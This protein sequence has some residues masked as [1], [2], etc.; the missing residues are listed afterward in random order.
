M[1]Y[2]CTP[3]FSLMI[4]GEMCGFFLIQERFETR[5]PSF[6]LVVCH[7]HGIFSQNLGENE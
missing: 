7:M 6:P 5:E 3:M 1:E 4:N 2:V